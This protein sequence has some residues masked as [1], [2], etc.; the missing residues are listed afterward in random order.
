MQYVISQQ[1]PPSMVV[2]PAVEHYQTKYHVSPHP[3]ATRA[4]ILLAAPGDKT[5]NIYINGKVKI[6][7]P[8]SNHGN[9]H[10][11]WS[12]EQGLPK[13]SVGFVETFDWIIV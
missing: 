11:L 4:Y 3:S 5:D 12:I 1:G 6:P 9:S 13:T 7:S 10:F 2:V 8:L